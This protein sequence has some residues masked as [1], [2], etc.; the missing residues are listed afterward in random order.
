MVPDSICFYYQFS[1]IL[2]CTQT[3]LKLKTGKC[4]WKNI[5]LSRLKIETISG[6]LNDYKP[7]YIELADVT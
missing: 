6:F 4:E 7:K 5:T 3:P 1:L 2:N